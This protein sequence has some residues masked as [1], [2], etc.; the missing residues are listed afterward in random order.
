MSEARR[1]SPLAGEAPRE[2]LARHLAALLA[3]LL[4]G[5]LWTW[6]LALG[7]GG[8]VIQR[9]T[10]PVDAGQGVWNLWW[11]WGAL[12][13]GASPYTTGHLFYPEQLS[14][15]YQTLSLPNALL[16][17]PLLAWAGPVAAFNGVVLLSFALGGYWAYRLC[18]ALGASTA[19]ALLGG[20]VYAFT[21]YHVQ[22]VWGGSMELIAVQWLALYALLLL[23]A[24]ARRTVGSAILAGAALFLVTLASQYYGLYAAV[25]TAA[26]GALAALLAPRGLR[27]RTLG[28]A[29]GAGLVWAALLGP[30]LL[31][32]GGLGDVILED[33]Y[34]RQAFHSVA[35]VDLVAP[36][37]LH[38]LWGA[39]AAAWH[40][41]IHPFGIESGAGLGLGAALLIAAA[42]WR[43]W[44][45][46][47]PWALLGLLMLL[48]A[49][50][51][52]LRLSAADSPV[53]GPFLLLD[54]F[55]PF[56]NSS[57]PAI[58]VALLLIPA[59]ALVALGF[60]ALRPARAPRSERAHGANRT[61][62]D[63]LGG[64]SRSSRASRFSPA[65]ALAALVAF[66][67]LVAP[68]ALMPLR[69]APGLAALNADPAP[70]A[71]LELPP[72][73]NDSRGLLGQLCH[74]RPLMGGYLARLPYYPIVSHPSATRALWLG[75]APAPDILP[76]SAAAELASL[77]VRYVAVDRDEYSRG[78]LRR[79]E[80]WLAEPGISR[81]GSAGTRDL[82]AVDPAAARPAAVLGAGWYEVESDG[83]RRWRWMGPRA[84]IA[85]LSR[86]PAAAT[87]SLRATAFGGPRE[88]RVWQGGRLL[89]AVEVPGAPYDRAMS[90][91]LLLPPGRTTVEL[92]SAAAPAPDGRS[93]SLSV[94]DVRL[95]P[96]AVDPAW[97]AQAALA[98]PPTL[99]AVAGAP[100]EAGGGR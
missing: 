16:V 11:A 68:W 85:L 96:L 71:L 82:F 45:A 13:R 55:G 76:L 27:L 7:A 2:T 42:L 83:A 32:A 57:R 97:A 84:E 49:M 52:M 89:A 62:R 69:A 28:A 33:W 73:L 20:F 79:L 31:L 43:R 3:Y 39:A 24:L 59:A 19:A 25:Y 17:A 44:R 53:P 36:H 66:E 40:G 98:I 56:R 91:S 93:L 6:P 99:P 92:E 51:P 75:Q 8:S 94:S 74:G 65:W 9:G 26:H 34:V 67:S 50:G 38:P 88:L 4:L 18:R 30:S 41:Q 86:G 12:A 15:F 80:Q 37:A 72:R 60:D 22:R 48:L 64:P 81:A 23:R 5:V 58:F 87:L 95:T 1:D 61:G 10:L 35:L 47:W 78:D 77:G 70:G 54:L 29:A 21:P 14:L 46:A 63:D 90:F 100:C